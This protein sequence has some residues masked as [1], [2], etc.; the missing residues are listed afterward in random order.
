MSLP[1]ADP[2]WQVL[3]PLFLGNSFNWLGLGALI[4]Q[5]YYYSQNF[6]QDTR[7]IRGLVY[8]LFILELVQ[9]V[10]TTHQAW[11]YIITDWNTPSALGGFPWSAMTVPV[12]AGIIAGVVQL[13]Y[14]WRIWT[15]SQGKI[16]R[17]C[18]VLIVF[19]AVAQCTSA[20]VG[21][22]IFQTNPTQEHLERLHPVL[23]FWLVA[24]FLTDVLVAACMLWLLYKAKS[25]STVADT[26]TLLSKLITNT[27]GT[28]T[29]TALCGTLTLALY[30][31]TV[32]FSFQYMPAAYILGK[33]YSNS[34][35]AALNARKLRNASGS[36]NG[37]PGDSIP[38][39]IYVS[40]DVDNDNPGSQKGDPAFKKMH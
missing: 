40:H 16:M 33:L 4:V 14:A 1:V 5:C 24:S 36:A 31:T 21:C 37:S 38:L 11:W 28:G 27:I 23:Y 15:L 30:V 13:F 34:V 2:T 32:G 3:A 6:T 39:H 18:T 20:V 19:L 29:A 17:C 35:M 26:G 10:T 12:M 9:T 22:S 7:A 8:G 25:Q